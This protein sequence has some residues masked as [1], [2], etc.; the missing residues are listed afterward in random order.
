MDGKKKDFNIG[1]AFIRIWMS[2]EVVLCHFWKQG[3]PELGDP[4]WIFSRMAQMAVPVFMLISFILTEKVIRYGKKQEV[5]S[6]YNRLLIPYITWPIICWSVYA[7]MEKR[8]SFDLINGMEDLGWQLLLGSSGYVTPQL[9]YQFDLMVLTLIFIAVF[10]I[11]KNNDHESC[12][13]CVIMIAALILQYSDLHG[14]FFEEARFEIK[15]SLGRLCEMIPY[16]CM[17]ILIQRYDLLNRVKKRRYETMLICVL[18]LGFLL[19]YEIFECPSGYGY[20]GMNSVCVAFFMVVLFYIAP[21]DKMPEFIIKII[22]GISKY[23][24]GIFCMHVMIGTILNLM[25]FPKFGWRTNTFKECILIYMICWASS[26]LVA[27]I[28]FQF[29]KRMVI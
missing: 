26:Y 1:L 18:M 16:A 9:R 25:V 11:I 12:I 7:L 8:F 14:D 3:K 23:S 24:L 17:G 15:Y 5:I 10:K 2:F 6:R 20:Q 21:F 13:L 19:R 28:P 27:K 22:A 29:G 4:L